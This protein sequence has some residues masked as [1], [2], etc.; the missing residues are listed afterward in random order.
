MLGKENYTKF[1]KTRIV[2][3]RALQIAQ[4]SPAM[5][6]VPRGDFDPIDLANREWELSIVPIDIRGK[7]V[8]PAVGDNSE[9]QNY[10]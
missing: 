3:A 6:E 5:V 7:K 8:N 1:E 4:G 2:S 10:S 9:P